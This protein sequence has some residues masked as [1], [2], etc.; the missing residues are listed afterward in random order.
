MKSYQLDD[1][2]KSLSSDIIKTREEFGLINKGIIK[3]FNKNI[4]YF[5]C[6]YK[7]KED[8]FDVQNSGKNFSKIFE[9][10][11]YSVLL[12]YT[13][14]EN[15]FGVFINKKNDTID[16]IQQEQ[17]QQTIEKNKS[18]LEQLL[19]KQQMQLEQQRH[20]EQQRK[21]QLEQQRKMQEQQILAKQMIK[22][23]QQV[24]TNQNMMQ[25]IANKEQGINSNNFDFSNNYQ[26]A[27]FAQSHKENGGA[28]M[29]FG[30]G[31]EYDMMGAGDGLEY[32][33]MG[34]GAG[35]NYGAQFDGYMNMNNINNYNQSSTSTVFYSNI[36][37]SDYFVFNLKYF[38]IYYSKEQNPWFESIPCFVVKYDTRR[39]VLFGCE[40]KF[41]QSKN[42]NQSFIFKLNG[43]DEFNIKYCELYEIQMSD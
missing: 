43:K 23:N 29:E 32:G 17:K 24:N 12:I 35:N 7:S 31:P 27:N 22:Q 15:K 21:M 9:K 1:I 28:G 26:K 30:A 37:L 16:K 20:F 36:S 11:E 18:M 3:L 39:Q 38:K 10:L 14:D 8:K 6:K 41:M 2:L 33:I 42:V 13:K 19:L 34:A 4:I 25:P 5:S 40:L